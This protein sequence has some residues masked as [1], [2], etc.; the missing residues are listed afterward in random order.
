LKENSYL[1]RI[2]QTRRP[3]RPRFRTRAIGPIGSSIPRAIII[4]HGGAQS[5]ARS[6]ETIE[7]DA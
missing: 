4:G 2:S 3:S 7:I 6:E 1:R 5:G